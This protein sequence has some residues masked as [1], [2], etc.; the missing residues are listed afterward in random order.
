MGESYANN[1]FQ[2]EQFVKSFSDISARWGMLPEEMAKAIAPLEALGVGVGVGGIEQTRKQAESTMLAA[3]EMVG[4]AFRG[5][6]IEAG[7]STRLLGTLSTT[8]NLT[9]DALKN[10]FLEIADAGKHSVFGMQGLMTQMVSMIESNR[11]YGLTLDNSVVSIGIWE[12]QL[13]RGTIALQDIVRF[14]TP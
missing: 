12:D 9:G 3:A 2:M 8:F 6:G 4:G 7:V 1:Y 10:T 5:F 11:R 13:K 14:S